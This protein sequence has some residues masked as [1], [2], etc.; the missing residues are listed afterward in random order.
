MA[1]RTRVVGRRISVGVVATSVRVVLITRGDGTDTRLRRGLNSVFSGDLLSVPLG[2]VFF[3]ESGVG[4][5]KI[6][7]HLRNGLALQNKRADFGVYSF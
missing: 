6:F 3:R 5:V 7:R 1:T 4:R 2:R